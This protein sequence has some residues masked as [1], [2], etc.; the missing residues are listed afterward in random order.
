MEALIGQ[1]V[2]EK[3]IFENNDHIKPCDRGRLPRF[4]RYNEDATCTLYGVEHESRLH[5]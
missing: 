2:S 4:N 5:F 3:M 1:G